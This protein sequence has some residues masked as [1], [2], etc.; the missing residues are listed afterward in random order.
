VLKILHNVKTRWIS[1]LSPTKRIFVEYKS[2]I[3]HMFDEQIANTW[4]KTNLDL[5]CNV[6]I[7]LDLIC[8]LPLFECMQSLSKFVQA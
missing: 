5:L 7:F 4:A 1:M 3:L 6:E 2:L 8:I